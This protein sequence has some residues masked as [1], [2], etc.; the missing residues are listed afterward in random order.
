MDLTFPLAG[1][2][3]AAKI[4]NP[5]APPFAVA[6]RQSPSGAPRTT[7]RPQ[8][9][10]RARLVVR[11]SDATRRLSRNA[12]HGRRG[13]AATVVPSRKSKPR[14]LSLL[15]NDDARGSAPCH[16]EITSAVH[17]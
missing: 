8:F 17:L 2:D 4:P 14:S 12:Y 1:P 7:Q 6:S 13:L 9:R 16:F 15:Y 5:N 11:T 10:L 3:L